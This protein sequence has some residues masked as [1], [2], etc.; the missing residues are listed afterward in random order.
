MA[1]IG[2]NIGQSCW[3]LADCHM[4]ME[5]WG[6]YYLDIGMAAAMPAIPELLICYY[7][8]YSSVKKHKEVH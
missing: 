5:Y 7:K 2:G 3:A 1:E 6:G 4:N 8:S